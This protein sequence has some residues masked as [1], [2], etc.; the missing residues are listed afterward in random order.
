MVDSN[1]YILGINCVYHESSACLLKDGQII[2][3]VEE[4]RFTRVKHAKLASV[5]NPDVLPVNAISFC[6]KEADITWNDIN[7]IG[8]SFE[9]KKWATQL[10]KSATIPGERKEGWGTIE[11]EEIFERKLKDIPYKLCQLDQEDITDKFLWLPHHLCHAGSAYFVSPYSE[12]AVLV[13]DGIGEVE[14]TTLYRGK[15]NILSEIEAI[16]CYPDSLGTLWETISVLMGFSKYDA[17]KVMGLAAYGKEDQ[18][19]LEMFKTFVKVQGPIFTIDPEVLQDN[20]FTDDCSELENLFGLQKRKLNEKLEQKHADI[21]LAL[22]NLTDTILLNIANYLYDRVQSPNLC[23]AGGVALNCVSNQILQEKSP[24]KNLYIQPAAH[25]AGTAIGAAYCIWN[26]TLRKPRSYIM[27]TPYLGPD[28]SSEEIQTVLDRNQLQ[29][30]QVDN[31]EEMT[32]TLIS[33]GNVIGWFQGKMEIGPRALGN[34]SLVADPRNPNMRE[35][36]NQKVKHREDFRPFAPSVLEEYAQDWFKLPGDSLALGFMLFACDAL[37][38]KQSLIPAILHVDGTSRV[39]VVNQ[40][41]NPKYHR[42][43]QAFYQITGVP[44]VLNTS[45][46]DTEPIVCSPEDAVKTF[47]KTKID[48][49]A[50]GDFLVRK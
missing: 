16:A 25:D 24:F 28:Y 29:Y 39:Q 31:I 9:P 18:E 35:I 42:L 17:T 15:D 2:A 50:I 26:Q 22:Q 48:Y 19:Y 6:L 32:A 12:A 44:L 30:S 3:A 20:D 37:E 43:I 7:F 5:D 23:L 21:A 27:K 8:Y 4:E 41:L 45:F 47:L 13:V 14:S 33:E 46:N 38:D 1:S 11:G 40:Q 36:M 49:L 34:R 10:D